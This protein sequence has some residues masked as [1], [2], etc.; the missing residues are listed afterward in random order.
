MS[1]VAKSLEAVS[2]Y[3]RRFKDTFATRR[4]RTFD[5]RDGALG[6]ALKNIEARS[7]DTYPAI[8][9]YD[10]ALAGL[11]ASALTG[12]VLTGTNLVGS[13]EKAEGATADSTGKITFT[14]VLPGEQT[15]TV[16]IEDTGAALAVT[17]DAAA[18]TIDIV[19]G[20][21]GSGA[22]GV[23]TAAEMIAAVNTHA[24]AKYMVDA[25]A[26]TAGDM[27][28]D[29]TVTVTTTGSDPGT[30]PVL[31]IGATAIDGTTAG[32]G[33]TAWSD[34]AITFD[35]D[36]SGLTAGSAKMLRLWV[37]DV[38]I[39]NVPLVAAAAS[40][41]TGELADGVLSA[42]ASGRGKMA[43]GF[44]GAGVAASAAHFA[45]NFFTSAVTLAKFAVGAL[46]YNTC[47]SIFAAGALN[48][49]KL[50]TAYLGPI[51]GTGAPQSTAHAL[52]RT[53]ALVI[54]IPVAGH[55]G[56]GGI[57]SQMPELTA[58]AH[59]GTN[60]IFTCEAGAKYMVLAF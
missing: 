31:Q 36:A 16:T 40:I 10:A 38:L 19:H 51:T 15:I 48:S 12:L 30:L 32:I 33:I 41:S 2:G 13:A 20:A 57:G 5:D 17:A 6:D 9:N 46:D 53:P 43:A 18:G 25:V 29:E 60:V 56:A 55:N 42:D 37:D 54:P 27:D 49:Q 1:L 24:E 35:F 52:G 34:T 45:D 11:A 4:H 28:A 59:D 22:G 39:L 8:T 58:G 47:S 3:T 26:T 21:G 23:A 7:D 44:F 14:A 50:S